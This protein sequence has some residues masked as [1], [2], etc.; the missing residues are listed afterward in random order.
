MASTTIIS[1]DRCKQS[2]ESEGCEWVHLEIAADLGSY[3][4]LVTENGDNANAI[5]L[6][7]QCEQ[8][9]VDWMRQGNSKP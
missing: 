3:I 7:D 4:R 2:R 1:C 8:L 6:C 5:D 9:F